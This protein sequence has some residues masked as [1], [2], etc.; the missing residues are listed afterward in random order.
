MHLRV[1]EVRLAEHEELRKIIH[2]LPFYEHFVFAGF[3][4]AASDYF[5]QKLDLNQHLIKHPESTYFVRVH[6]DSMEGAGIHSGDILIVDR[7]LEPAD[8][9]VIVACI[10]GDLIV[11]R[12]RII[13]GRYFLFSENENYLPIEITPDI[14]FDIFGV[15]LHAIHKV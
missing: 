14:D 11:K 12:L 4:S 13:E 15:V 9:N 3:P 2:D 10:G 1:I 5:K 6:G 8:N 7:A